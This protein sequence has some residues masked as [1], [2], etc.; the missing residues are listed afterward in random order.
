MRRRLDING[1]ER[2]LRYI[3]PLQSVDSYDKRFSPVFFGPIETNLG[4][5]LA[6]EKTDS[7]PGEGIYVLKNSAQ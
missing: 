6:F 5:G 4:P 3:R 1:N 2:E 7:G